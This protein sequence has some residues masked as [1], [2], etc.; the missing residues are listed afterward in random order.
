M[1]LCPTPALFSPCKN[2]KGVGHRRSYHGGCVRSE[3]M[4]G[5]VLTIHPT[6][7]LMEGFLLVLL[8]LIRSRNFNTNI[9]AWTSRELACIYFCMGRPQA[10]AVTI[11]GNSHHHHYYPPLP[12][13]SL[14]EFAPRFRKVSSEKSL[15]VPFRSV[16][17]RPAHPS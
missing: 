13:Q 5:N 15:S 2:G 17:S 14:A 12:L 4:H 8:F 1:P 3:W 11:L 16:P 6:N 9:Q 10:E 7:F